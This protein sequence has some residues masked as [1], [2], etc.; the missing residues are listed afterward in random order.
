M[1][2]TSLMLAATAY[3]LATPASEEATERYQ[4]SIV[5]AITDAA[6]AQLLAIVVRVPDSIAEFV[7]DW[8]CDHGYTVVEVQEQIEDWTFYQIGWGK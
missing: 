8:L 5:S 3:L 6:Y 1:A 2:D 7:K 4:E